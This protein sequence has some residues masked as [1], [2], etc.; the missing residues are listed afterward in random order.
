MFVLELADVEHT[1]ARFVAFEK[2]RDLQIAALGHLISQCLLTSV[3]RSS[4]TL[5]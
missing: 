5:A 1:T 4:T 2:F 3:N